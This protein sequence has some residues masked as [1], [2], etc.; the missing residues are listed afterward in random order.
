MHSWICDDDNLIV[1]KIR[2]KKL[3]IS[4]AVSIFLIILFAVIAVLTLSGCAGNDE[5]GPSTSPVDIK[6][7]TD[8]YYTDEGEY[9]RPGQVYDEPAETKEQA[10]EKGKTILTL[11]DY[12]ENTVLS[13]IIRDFNLSNELYHVELETMD[14]LT[15]NED[16]VRLNME[17]SS[18]K[19]PDILTYHAFPDVT[20]TM[21]KGCYLDLT[22]FLDEIGVDESTY[23]PAVYAYTYDDKVYGVCINL[24][25]LVV[26][27][28]EDLLGGTDTIEFSEYI[29]KLL[30]YPKD[31][32]FY[33]DYQTSEYILNTLL[34]SSDSLRGT[35]DKKNKTCDF[36]TELFYKLL[37]VSKRYGD[38]KDK[39]YP[40]VMQ[41]FT[42]GSGE[43]PGERVLH[44][45]GW[46]T[47]NEW[48]DE[49]NYPV[50]GTGDSLFVNSATEYPEGAKAFV[51]F[52]LSAYGQSYVS[53]PVNKSTFDSVMADKL[54]M[55]IFGREYDLTEEIIAD[56]RSMCEKAKYPPDNE[57]I[58]NII[59]EE[60]GAYFSGDKTKEEVC[61]IIQSRVRLYLAEQK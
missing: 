38:A 12:N 8:Y 40:N 39:G 27:V 29:D 25:C 45:N 13:G 3:I 59:L 19:G 54:T 9:T 57:D 30:N 28:K 53:Y 56:T 16:R 49:G 61:D 26:C 34:Q 5:N 6:E 17:L 33:N 43:Y 23:F 35:V 10:I 18:G 11:Q 48:F 15:T 7:E 2:L 51:S 52:A 55:N 46:V 24:A 14:P 31:A 36:H 60:T 44:E 58:L 1:E 21:S 47:V 22:S 32:V 42:V 37:D 41:P 4:A 50:Y 20:R